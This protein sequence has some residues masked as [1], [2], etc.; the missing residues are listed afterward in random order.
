MRPCRGEQRKTSAL[1]SSPQTNGCVE[2]VQRTVLEECWRPTF[3]R[4]L[5]PKYTAL[6]R[7]LERY[8]AYFKLRSRGPRPL[9]QGQD[10]RRGRLWFSEDASELTEV[11]NGLPPG[12][13]FEDGVAA[14]HE[15]ENLVEIVS[16]REDGC[17]FRVDRS[18]HKLS[19]RVP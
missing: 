8:V 13:A 10:A 15:D 18:E 19:V 5:V 2:R 7:D 12:I 16:A 17:A 11:A 6:R 9:H 14:L 3:A 1:L 4:S